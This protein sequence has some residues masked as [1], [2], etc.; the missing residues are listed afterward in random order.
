MGK[1]TLGIL[2]ADRVDGPLK[3]LYGDYPA[4]FEALLRDG[5][6]ASAGSRVC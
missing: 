6:S 4:M 1:R 2:E 5:E 3:D